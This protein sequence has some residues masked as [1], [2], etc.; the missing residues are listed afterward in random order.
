VKYRHSYHAGN[1][2]D[3][4]KHATLLALLAAL[5]RK[6]KGFLYFDS[7]AGRGSYELAAGGGEAQGGVGPFLDH[8]HRAEELRNYAALLARFRSVRGNSQFYPGS[9]LLAAHELRA[10][11]RGV[12]VELQGAEAHAL[13]ASLEAL[14]PQSA[15]ARLRV[16]RGD[17]LK[18]LHAALPPPERRA[19]LFI[20]PPYEETREELPRVAAAVQDGL[21]RFATGVFAVWY[22]IK[23]RRVTAAWHAD[24]SREVLV[25]T[26]VSELWLY[27]PDSRVSLNG[28]G[29]LIV[30]PPWQIAERMRDWLP[31]LAAALG[32]GGSGGAD[33]RMLS[34]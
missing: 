8:P 25:P 33:V 18:L 20:D 17:G 22:P 11:D 27:P 24:W 7:H 5:K 21:R 3:V 29:V 30:N 13:S 6:D 14:A 28:S 31:E 12:F 2:A 4:H 9:P 34:Q 16:E 23:E 19:L 26:L 1:F 10:Q 32:A 15:S